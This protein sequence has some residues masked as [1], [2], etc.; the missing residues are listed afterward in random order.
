MFTLKVQWVQMFIRTA[1]QSIT[2]KRKSSLPKQLSKLK[3]SAT[4][5]FKS[6]HQPKIRERALLLLDRDQPPE[7]LTMVDPN[8]T[9]E[10]KAKRAQRL[11]AWQ[12]SRWIAASSQLM[13]EYKDSGRWEELEARASSLQDESTTLSPEAQRQ[14]REKA[15]PLFR[16]FAKY[17]YQHLGIRM[18]IAYGY[19]NRTTEG[20][21]EGSINVNM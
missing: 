11:R 20:D 10:A 12:A 1:A 19:E 14:N 7:E 8:A 21:P 9:A 17:A 5:L 15:L 13:K 16:D 6:E 4:R 3:P 2:T 18:V